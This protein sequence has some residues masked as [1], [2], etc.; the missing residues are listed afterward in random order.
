[1]EVWLHTFLTLALYG[2]S[3]Q[4]HTPAALPLVAIEYEAA[5]APRAG[6][7]DVW[8]KENPLPLPRMELRPDY[9]TAHE[10]RAQT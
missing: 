10:M 7:R 2:D 4:F 5:W 6:F 3:G 1:M 9:D 8:K